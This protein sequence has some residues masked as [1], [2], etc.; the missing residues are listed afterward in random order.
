MSRALSGSTLPLGWRWVTADAAGVEV[1]DC[2]HSTP[3]LVADGPFVVRTQDIDSGTFRSENA[4]HVSVETYRDRVARAEPRYG[5]VL[6]SREGAYYGVAA[7]VPADTLVCLGQRMVL[8]R[9]PANVVDHRYL[10]FWMNSPAG[11]AYAESHREGSAAPR[12]NLPT[13]RS[14]P[15]PLP[16]IYEQHAIATTLGALD[17]KIESNRRLITLAEELARAHFTR[18]FAVDY[19]DSGVPLS[20]LVTINPR[21]ILPIGEVSTYIGMASLPEF[22][23]EIYEWEQKPAGSGQR[24]ENGDV[25][26]ARITPCLENG[27]TAIVDMLEPGEVGWGSTEYVVLTPNN[28]VSTPWI[29]CLVRDDRIRDFAIRSMIGTSGRQRFQADRFDQ[30]MITPPTSKAFDE[31]NN[32]ATPLFTRMT[33][34]RDQVKKLSLLR[35]ALVPEILSGRIRVPDAAEVAV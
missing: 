34:L 24:F 15:I 5:D 2:P 16:P 19:V 21:R 29:Y 23:A 30:Y 4:A 7:E 9:P 28:Q 13:I 32:I 18:L 27:K 26:M 11:R 8:I 31:F 20:T 1:F 22:S 25:L 17:G 33:Q 6:Y 3:K 12:I 35:D 10:K 14:F